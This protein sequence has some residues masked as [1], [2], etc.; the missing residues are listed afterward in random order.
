MADL[1]FWEDWVVILSISYYIGS[2]IE[3]IDPEL[4]AAT[5]V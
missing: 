4:V 5:K 1:S 3:D 2:E